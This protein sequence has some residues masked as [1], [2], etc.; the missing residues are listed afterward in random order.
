MA[1]SDNERHLKATDVPPLTIS[2]SENHI[3]SSLN[4]M[5]DVELQNR[6]PIEVTQPKRTKPTIVRAD[7]VILQVWQT[8][9]IKSVGEEEGRKVMKG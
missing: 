8:F 9:Q 3:K 4:P 5:H 1:D 7:T 6:K 2:A